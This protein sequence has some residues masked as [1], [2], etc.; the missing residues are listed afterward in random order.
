MILRHSIAV[1][2]FCCAL[3]LTQCKSDCVKD[4]TCDPPVFYEFNLDSLKDYLIAEQGS[5]W[6]YKNTLNNELDTQI[7]YGYSI[8]TITR[9]GTES[10]ADHITIKYQRY[11]G[12]QYS[13][14]YKWDITQMTNQL[15]PEN[16]RNYSKKT[17]LTRYVQSGLVVCFFYPFDKNFTSGTGSHTCKFI[18]MDSTF[19]LQGKT[20]ENVAKFFVDIDGTWGNNPPFTYGGV[21]YYWAKGVGLIK[22]ESNY[23]PANWEL[24]EYNIIQ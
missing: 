14:R 11:Y 16:M 12:Q 4:G 1:V 6:I 8:D 24:I 9:R 22:K 7:S 10:W 2:S 13:S 5:Y 23:N 19:V 17:I 21:T 3:L 18:G 20:Y 15:Y